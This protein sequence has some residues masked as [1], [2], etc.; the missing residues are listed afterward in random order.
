MKITVDSRE[1]K[2]IIEYIKNLGVMVEIEKLDIGD[3]L[4]GDVLIERKTLTDFLNSV[5]SRRLWEQLYQMKLSNLKCFLAVIGE[6]SQ[7]YHKHVKSWF[8]YKSYILNTLLSV[9]IVSFLSY[10]V[11][12]IHLNDESEFLEFIRLTYHRSGKKET[13]RPVKRKSI[14]YY[15][16]VLIENV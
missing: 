12:F 15:D 6:I 10:N 16:I 8:Q 9:R 5:R 13:V 7:A 4:I 3:Y 14:K 11:A 1:P 2:Y